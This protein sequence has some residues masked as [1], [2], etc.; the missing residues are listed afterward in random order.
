M[1]ATKVING[2]TFYARTSGTKTK[3]DREAR[4]L[5]AQG[6]DCSVRKV[7]NKYILY[8]EKPGPNYTFIRTLKTKEKGK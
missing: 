2:K 4:K 6:K 8:V 7:G 1:R 3:C 5:E